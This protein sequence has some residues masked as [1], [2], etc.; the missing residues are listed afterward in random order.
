MG[1]FV[2]MQ[3]VQKFDLIPQDLAVSA[4]RRTLHAFP[5]AVPQAWAEYLSRDL[6]TFKLANLN[7]RQIETATIRAAATPMATVLANF[8]DF[9]LV[10]GLA[11]MAFQSDPRRPA[12]LEGLYRWGAQQLHAYGEA[13]A[14][15][16]AGVA[17]Q[18]FRWCVAESHDRVIVVDS[19]LG[20]TLPAQVIGRLLQTKGVQVE[21]REFLAPRLD[22][23]AKKF[24][25]KEAAAEFCRSLPPDNFPVIFP[26]EVL[27][28][29]R[30]RKLYRALGKGLGDRVVPVALSVH[31]MTGSSN[32]IKKVKKLQA[33]LSGLKCAKQGAPVFTRLPTAT[34]VKIDEG[35]PLTLSA[36]FFW[37]EMDLAAG[38]RKVNLVFSFMDQMK[39]LARGLADKNGELMSALERMWRQSSDGMLIS[40]AEPYLRQMVPK[41]AAE[42][43]WEAI[44]DEARDVFKAEYMGAAPSTDMESVRVRFD[45]VLKA[46][47][48][49]LIPTCSEWSGG[50]SP[51]G[52]VV[53]ALRDLYALTYE[54]QH[55][56]SPRDRDFCECTI[57]VVHPDLAFHEELVRL[58]LAQALAL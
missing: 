11:G 22:R 28:G 20:G 46:V 35:A 27:T 43:D 41:L 6:R 25:L 14:A 8:L 15:S 55:K 53:N 33:E 16:L 2:P 30:F 7:A 52:L 56:G 26:D 17:N 34:L 10:V 37:A 49:Q 18:I 29:T 45:W 57:P 32:D 5:E 58:I 51:A 24:S 12:G 50:G 44:E 42:I 36:P 48:D 40:G 31:S 21:I 3:L 38:K 4:V 9:E 47:Y 23:H 19:P 39:G 54:V 13:Q 1:R